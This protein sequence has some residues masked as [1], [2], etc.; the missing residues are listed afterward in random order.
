MFTHL[1]V[2]G[3]EISL[4]FFFKSCAFS[5]LMMDE[6]SIVSGVIKAWLLV[7]SKREMAVS[8]SEF[9]SNRSH[10]APILARVI[11]LMCSFIRIVYRA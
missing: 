4:F 8:K 6:V 1:E 5:A 11:Y 10:L 2:V 9:L 7:V 3:S